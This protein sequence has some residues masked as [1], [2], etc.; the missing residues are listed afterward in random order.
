[1]YKKINLIN[2]NNI[3][4]KEV[5][6]SMISGIV[7]AIMVLLFC[8]FPIYMTAGTLLGA[9]IILTGVYIS[10]A[11]MKYILIASVVLIS[12]S[13]LIYCAIKIGKFTFETIKH[14]LKGVFK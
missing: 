7:L 13:I 12:L 14:I 1:M 8:A 11:F 4:Q 9:S 3:K 2:T 6:S 5:V 10:V